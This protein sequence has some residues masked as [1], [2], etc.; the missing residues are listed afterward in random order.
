MGSQAAAMQEH[1]HRLL[2][3][4][5][6]GR[7][8]SRANP[9]RLTNRSDMKDGGEGIEAGDGSGNGNGTGPSP[10]HRAS[11]AGM[12]PADGDGTADSGMANGPSG[13]GGGESRRRSRNSAQQPTPLAQP[14]S[15]LRRVSAGVSQPPTPPPQFRASLDGAREG[16]SVPKL[17]GCCHVA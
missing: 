14:P 11:H 13:G 8:R 6:D 7:A 4:D 3:G 10:F 16:N 5:V 17:A 15:S 9:S 12:D 1:I 2:S